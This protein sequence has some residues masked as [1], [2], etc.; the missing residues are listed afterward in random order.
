M[1]KRSRRAKSEP[2]AVRRKWRHQ[3]NEGGGIVDLKGGTNHV[4]FIR[5]EKRRAWFYLLEM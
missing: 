2:E 1:D 3:R 4:E 5:K